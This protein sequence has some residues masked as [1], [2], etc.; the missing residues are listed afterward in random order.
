MFFACRIVSR[1]SFRTSSDS[2]GKS[3]Q[4]W[5]EEQE[6]R[7][8]PFSEGATVTCMQRVLAVCKYG[9]REDIHSSSWILAKYLEDCVEKELEE[10]G[11][12]GEGEGENRRKTKTY[13]GDQK[14]EKIAL[15]PPS[16]AFAG[17]REI[18][19]CLESLHAFL[20]M[21]KR[22]EQ[23]AQEEGAAPAAS[24]LM[25]R[26]SGDEALLLVPFGWLKREEE[27][28][29]EAGGHDDD[30]DEQSALGKRER[31]KFSF[32]FSTFQVY[33][34]LLLDVR[35]LTIACERLRM[36]CLEERRRLP[37]RKEIRT[38]RGGDQDVTMTTRRSPAFPAIAR[39]R[40][41]D[42]Q[43]HLLSVSIE[44]AYLWIS[45]VFHSE[46]EASRSREEQR[47]DEEAFS[48]TAFE[49]ERRQMGGGD[50]ERDD[51]NARRGLSSDVQGVEKHVVVSPG[52]QSLAVAGER[53][54]PLLESVAFEGR[55][56]PHTLPSTSRM[57][58]PL[59]TGTSSSPNRGSTTA[60]RHEPTLELT[61]EDSSISPFFSIEGGDEDAE[62]VIPG[63][64]GRDAREGGIEITDA[65][66]LQKA[67]E[68]YE[69]LVF[70]LSLHNNQLLSS[71]LLQ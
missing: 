5:S 28:G 44:L 25:Q 59:L 24:G 17:T 55:W 20:R 38:K 43:V 45:S 9:W 11:G 63:L 68:A 47:Q 58:A 2:D 41:E 54:L 30:G 39:M 23:Q 32:F 62:D 52:L 51:R 16:I 34:S 46:G 65:H 60:D 8:F 6:E 26:G 19:A 57:H 7:E 14:N 53:L 56:Q 66:V 15:I 21:Q 1:I 12:G 61:K 35:K 33:L 37:T 64:H 22:R 3:Q 27:E 10:G 49:R 36:Q 71:S 67:R 48:N 29:T 31:E 70:L 13:A 40:V 69:K 4:E 18:V 50:Q 42:L